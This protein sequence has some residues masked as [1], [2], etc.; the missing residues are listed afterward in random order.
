M[1]CILPHKG[2]FS[3]QILPW[4]FVLSEFRQSMDGPTYGTLSQRQTQQRDRRAMRA[5]I[6]ALEYKKLQEAEE[7]DPGK[8]NPQFPVL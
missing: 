5:T 1:L 8:G 4:L 7:D 2:I 3:C 6:L